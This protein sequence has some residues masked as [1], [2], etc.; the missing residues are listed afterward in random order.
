[1]HRLHILLQNTV[2]LEGL[3]VGQT[4]TAVNGVIGGKFINR[5]PLRS[6]D[7]APRQTTAQQHRMTRLQLLCRT[8]GAN[9][10]VIL[11]IHAV[12]ANQQKVVAF[13]AAGKGVV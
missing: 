13:K 6:G 3:A 11:L 8:L 1:M 4:N 5:L 9:V 7:H 10:A 2:E 12:K